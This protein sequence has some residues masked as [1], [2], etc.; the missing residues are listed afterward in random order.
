MGSPPLSLQV[1]CYAGHKAFERPVAF[2]HGAR[3]VRVTEI[4][5]AWRGPDHA[6]FKLTGS[7]G[8]R[9]VIRH[10]QETDAWE[11]ILMEVPPVPGR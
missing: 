9:Y 3:E 6:Y 5:D 2:R 1:E 10:D 4:L 8:C 11:L 7:D